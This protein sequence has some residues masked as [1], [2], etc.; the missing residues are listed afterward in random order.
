M[1]YLLNKSF[2]RLCEQNKTLESNKNMQLLRGEGGSVRSKLTSATMK[3]KVLT[4]TK[5]K[6]ATNATPMRP[7]DRRA[8][9]DRRTM[10]LT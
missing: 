9:H 1:R 6:T 8:M 7:S 3:A 5:L 4:Q 10:S 2:C